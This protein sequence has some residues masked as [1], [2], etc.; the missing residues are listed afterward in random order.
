MQP[1]SIRYVHGHYE[2]YLHGSFR[3]S[4]DTMPEAYNEIATEDGTHEAEEHG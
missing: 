3:F 4:A 2:V 1:Y